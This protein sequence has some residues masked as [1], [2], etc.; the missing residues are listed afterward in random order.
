MTTFH[1]REEAFEAKFAHDEEFRFLVTARRDKLFAR[2]AAAK[3]SM[4]TERTDA[5]TNAVL[6]ITSHCHWAWPRR[7][8]APAHRGRLGGGRRGS[9]GKRTVSCSGTV[10]RTST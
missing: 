6:V 8:P 5:L 4:S 9:E 7:R 1:E 10:R 2:W 3:L